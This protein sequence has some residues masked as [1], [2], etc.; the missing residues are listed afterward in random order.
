MTTTLAQLRTLTIHKLGLTSGDGRL[1]DIDV[2]INS[3]LRA[4]ATDYDWPWLIRSTTFDTVDG[5]EAYNTPA[6][7]TRTRSL[8]IS[9]TTAPV[10]S[11]PLLESVQ[12]EKLLEYEGISGLPVAYCEE[13][14]QL[15][16]GPIPNQVWTIKHIYVVAEN[17]LTA[18]ADTVICPDWYIDIIATYGALEESRRR[19]DSVLTSMLE[20]ARG[21]WL[22]RL[23]DQIVRT[24]DLPS[25]RMRGDW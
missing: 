2:S 19:E 18:D 22:K 4:M 9:P 12:R 13:N 6:R 8:S 1:A 17:T 23:Q 24:K 14:S 15:L 21:E 7:W 3:G 25:I 10:Y 11:V 20:S 5:T 16:L